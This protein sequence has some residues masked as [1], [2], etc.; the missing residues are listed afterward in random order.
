MNFFFYAV[1]LLTW[2]DSQALNINQFNT[3]LPL[4]SF[5]GYGCFSD[6]WQIIYKFSNWKIYDDLHFDYNKFWISQ[7]LSIILNLCRASDA[8][9]SSTCVTVFVYRTVAWLQVL[10]MQG[11]LANFLKTLLAADNRTKFSISSH[12]A[13]K[14]INTNVEIAYECRVLVPLFGIITIAIAKICWLIVN[15][16]IFIG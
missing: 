13:M 12:L 8:V 5:D 2:T 16:M 7:T 15:D 6:V 3:V 11:W 1:I 9:E 10:S 4:C 14:Q